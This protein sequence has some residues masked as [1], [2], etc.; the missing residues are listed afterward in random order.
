MSYQQN[1]VTDNRCLPTDGSSSKSALCVTDELKFL[2]QDG[3]VTAADTNN[4]SELPPWFDLDKFRRSV[5]GGCY[6]DM[7]PIKNNEMETFLVTR[8]LK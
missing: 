5:I 8:Y 6:R 3:S 7:K 1:A 2:L 4:T